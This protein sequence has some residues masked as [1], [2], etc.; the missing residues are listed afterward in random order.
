MSS[1]TTND[2][3]MLV[4]YLIFIIVATPAIILLLMRSASRTRAK[5]AARG[6]NTDGGAAVMAPAHRRDLLR[7]PAVKRLLKMR[8]FQFIMQL[9]NVIVFG[10]VI[11]AG[12]WG[13]QL[14]DKNF[15]TVLTWLVWWAVIIFTFL[16]LS[17]TWCMACP[18]VSVAEW[19]QRGKLWGVSKRSISLNRK[20]PRKLRN[21]WIP[22][23]FFI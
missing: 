1:Q 18:L 9:P 2:F 7:I 3:S 6:Q 20:W 4:P 11:A 5:A 19:I 12:I 15:A 21:F 23:V 14:G 10:L 13:T 16:F 22:T 8:A 17:R